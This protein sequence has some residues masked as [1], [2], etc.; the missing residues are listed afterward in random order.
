MK[1]DFYISSLSGGGAEKVLIIL[2]ELF[3][4]KGYDVMIHSLE[5]RE[6]FYQVSS[7]VK[8]NKVKKIKYGLFGIFNDFK[9][10]NFS[11]KKRKADIVI[12]FLLRTNIL[13]LFCSLFKKTRVIV[14]DRNN[15]KT[16]HS[17]VV[18]FLVQFLYRK[19]KAVV[20]QTQKIKSMYFNFILNKIMVIENPVDFDSLNNQLEFD[21][22]GNIETL[23]RI[24]SVGRLEKQKDFKTLITAFGL[25][26]NQFP[27]WKLDIYGIGEKQKE[28]EEYIYNLP[29]ENN[30]IKLCGRTKKPFYEM[31]RSKIFVLSSFYEGFPN[32]L[33][34]AMYAKLVCISSDCISGPSELINNRENGYL[35]EVGNIKELS[36][37]LRET[38]L[39]YEKLNFMKEKAY[40]RILLLDKE[41]IFSKWEKLVISLIKEK[42]NGKDINRS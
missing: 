11:L 4:K 30:Q 39:H 40:K 33:C 32:V 26:K 3:A 10:I 42:K 20:V 41:I 38:I 17:L 12:S 25:I 34:E 18:F 2:A 19:A 1:I 35:F 29:D 23:N 24:I 31:K 27:K 14:C 13:V 6:Q 9:F 22:I 16:E 36:N 8:I 5:K 21:E 37:L 28:L 15:P 7:S